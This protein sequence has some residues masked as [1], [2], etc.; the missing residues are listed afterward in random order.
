MPGTV[1]VPAR[2][3]PTGTFQP[4]LPYEQQQVSALTEGGAEPGPDPSSTAESL[5]AGLLLMLGAAHLRTRLRG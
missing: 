2:P 3:L 4:G 5:A 1:L